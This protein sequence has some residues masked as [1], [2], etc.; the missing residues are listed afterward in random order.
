MLSEGYGFMKKGRLLIV[1]DDND[2][3]RLL[4]LYFT[5]NGYSVDVAE[6]GSRVFDFIQ[7]RLP[8]LII[9]D[10]MLPDTDGYKICRQLRTTTRTGHIPIIFLTEKDARRDRIAGLE[11]GADDYV[12]K[13]FDIEELGLRVK[14]TVERHR[15]MNMTDPRTGLPA[16]PLIEE[17]LRALMSRAGWTYI[18]L[19]LDHFAAFRDAYGFVA[20]DEVMRH[21]ALL[22]SDAVARFGTA[23][24]FVGHAGGQTLVIITYGDRS[25]QIIREVRRQFS[26][27]VATHYNFLDSEQGGI[28]QADGVLAPLMRLSIGSVSDLEGRFADIREITET[29]AARSVLERQA[30][31]NDHRGNGRGNLAGRKPS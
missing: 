31:G 14:N 5:R 8:D 17:Q 21:V 16:G 26:A 23:Q 28:R 25:E 15:R 20:G 12:T 1:E 7:V 2:T 22:V 13:P 18:E 30:A 10:I 29:A 11:L 27:S 9:L 4:D 24:D 3:A 6:R 19:T